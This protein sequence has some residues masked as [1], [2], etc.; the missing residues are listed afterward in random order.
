M[1]IIIVLFLLL[2]STVFAADTPT[3]L[4]PQQAETTDAIARQIGWLVIQNANLQAQI[5]DLKKR[6]AE[7]P[8]K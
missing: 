8:G 6:L 1:R 5:D 3:L 4:Q 7:C 2:S